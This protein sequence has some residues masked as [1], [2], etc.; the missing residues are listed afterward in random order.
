MTGDKTKAMSSCHACAQACEECVASCLRNTE[1][2]HMAPCILS[3][4]D[5]AQI[6]RTCAGL[7]ARDSRHT[8]DA[9]RLCVAV[10]QECA[11]ICSQYDNDHCQ[12]C[13]AICRQ[14]VDACLLLNGD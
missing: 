5:C 14:C 9:V 7:I 13:A 8:A 10:C 6:C 12:S 1:M 3:N 2:A 11:D 4:L